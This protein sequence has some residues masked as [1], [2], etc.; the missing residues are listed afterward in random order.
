MTK[1]GIL[2]RL[3]C[4]QS[5]GGHLEI[6]N[7]RFE[8]RIPV[9]YYN[10]S[11]KTLTLNN[12][13]CCANSK[14]IKVGIIY[15]PCKEQTVTIGLA[16][17]AVIAHIKQYVKMLY[18]ELIQNC[19]N[20]L[21]YFGVVGR[22]DTFSFLY[23]KL[24]GTTATERTLFLKRNSVVNPCLLI[25]SSERTIITKRWFPLCPYGSTLLPCVFVLHV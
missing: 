17:I 13:T 9:F 2:L 18:K 23:N 15:E 8:Q 5:L 21:F 6:G 20:G 14:T 24:I 1:R 22:T 10:G 3:A 12:G 16:P 4:Y 7:N 11:I 19:Q 25:L